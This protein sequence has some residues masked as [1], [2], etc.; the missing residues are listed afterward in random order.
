MH[1][2]KVTDNAKTDEFQASQEEIIEVRAIL[3]KIFAIL[4]K[5]RKWLD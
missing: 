2:P 5:P 3:Y 1:F 4:H